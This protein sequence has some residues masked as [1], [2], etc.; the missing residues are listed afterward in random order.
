M[1][2][3]ELAKLKWKKLAL[4]TYQFESSR[5]CFCLN[6][7]RLV[8]IKVTNNVITE[9]QV[10]E[11]GVALSADQV[12]ELK[13]IDQ[14]FDLLERA[15][16]TATGTWSATFDPARGYPTSISVDWIKQAVDDEEGYTA[17]LLAPQ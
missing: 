9:A 15:S 12:A 16:T 1:T 8:D 2:E 17:K 7:G 10:K 3:L 4:T 13:T 6:A 14:L 11:T 5:S